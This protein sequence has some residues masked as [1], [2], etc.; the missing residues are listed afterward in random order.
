MAKAAARGR[1]AKEEAGSRE[2]ALKLASEA[3]GLALLWTLGAEWGADLRERRI[4]LAVLCVGGFVSGAAL[5][6]LQRAVAE[7]LIP[8]L[9]GA[10]TVTAV[11][12]LVVAVSKWTKPTPEDVIEVFFAEDA[13]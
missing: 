4:G 13:A 7:R 6:L 2:A 3:A 8:L 11:L 9:A 12:V 5:I 10:V 1:R